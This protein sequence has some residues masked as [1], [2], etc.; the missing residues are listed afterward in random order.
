M[1]GAIDLDLI[2][3]IYD[4]PI[5]Q[6]GWTPVLDC[7]RRLIG[8]E[9][10]VLM[11]RRPGNGEPLDLSLSAGD[12]ETWQ[13]Y[14]RRFAA[15]DP[16]LDALQARG[17]QPGDA[18]TDTQLL[19]PRTLAATPFF[20]EFL[21]PRAIGHAAGAYLQDANGLVRHLLLPR[22]VGDRAY[23]EPRRR[24]LQLYVRHLFRALQL[25]SLLKP[26]P[27]RRTPPDLDQFARTH[28]LTPAEVRLV[29]LLPRAGSLRGAAS[30]L[31]RSHNT[32]R[33]QMRSVLAKT[34]TKSQVEL[35][36]LLLGRNAGP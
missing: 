6:S 19:A 7:L 10:A 31:Q 2:E 12:A 21:R 29:D 18:V 24:R 3:Q 23:S 4:V 17:V 15:T 30:R 22:A 26:A 33:A 28:R 20:Q 13:L 32:V 27:P 5:S 16:F 35:L 8:A 1:S 36:G 11:T 34:G 25:Q 9:S 14:S